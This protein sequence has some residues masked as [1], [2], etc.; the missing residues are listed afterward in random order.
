MAASRALSAGEEEATG[1][2]TESSAG[3]QLDVGEEG[4]V[5]PL[6][7]ATQHTRGLIPA[8]AVA[9]GQS[10]TPGLPPRRSRV[11][12]ALPPRSS[13]RRAA[14]R[15]ALTVRQGGALHHRAE[16][17]VHVHAVGLHRELVLGERLQ[18]ADE[19]VFSRAAA[20]NGRGP[21]TQPSDGPPRGP[22]MPPPTIPPQ[23]RTAQGL[24]RHAP[25]Q[26]GSDPAVA[27]IGGA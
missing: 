4:L 17:P 15:G 27:L 21:R 19:D 11:C 24:P 3:V 14:G 22:A 1:G 6:P 12:S 16:G 10:F 25:R 9:G 5:S 26:A 18:P 23:L 8:R 7:P 13:A 20:G 2:V